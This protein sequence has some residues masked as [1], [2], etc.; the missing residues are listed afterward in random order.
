MNS[1]ECKTV[2]IES[3]RWCPYKDT[4]LSQAQGLCGQPLESPAESTVSFGQWLLLFANLLLSLP[5]PAAG[6]W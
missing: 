5:V 4:A 3:V 1:T 2:N 6:S